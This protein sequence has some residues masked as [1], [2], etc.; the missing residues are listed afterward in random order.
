MARPGLTGKQETQLCYD[1]TE[2]PTD[3]LGYKEKPQCRR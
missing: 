1:S 3:T 2:T